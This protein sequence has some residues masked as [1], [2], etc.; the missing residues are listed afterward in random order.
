MTLLLGWVNDEPAQ[1]SD[2]AERE[3]NSTSAEARGPSG[4][5]DNPVKSAAAI[6]A[7][8]VLSTASAASALVSRA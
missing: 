4:I 7:G 3:S 2:K 5:P 8:G 6:W 1:N